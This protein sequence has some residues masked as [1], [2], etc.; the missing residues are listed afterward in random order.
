MS[1]ERYVG[2]VKLAIESGRIRNTQGIE[3]FDERLRGIVNLGY[4]NKGS[5]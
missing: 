1:C 5:K 4:D 3:N 2:F